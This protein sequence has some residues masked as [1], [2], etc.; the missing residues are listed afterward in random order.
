MNSDSLVL[1]GPAALEECKAYLEHRRAEVIAYVRDVWLKFLFGETISRTL[2]FETVSQLPEE[3]KAKHLRDLPSRHNMRKA[4]ALGHI[5]WSV[6]FGEAWLKYGE[7]V[8]KEAQKSLFPEHDGDLAIAEL[9]PSVQFGLLPLGEDPD[10]L[11]TC[12]EP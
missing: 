2:N 7:K 11:W 6:Y 1:E 5:R 8:A 9:L 4:Y 12:P 10:Y 3:W